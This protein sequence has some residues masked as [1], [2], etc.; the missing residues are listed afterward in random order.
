MR[1]ADGAQR[2]GILAFFAPVCREDQ[3]QWRRKTPKQPVCGSPHGKRR[4]MELEDDGTGAGSS[5]Q[6]KRPRGS[7]VQK[8]DANGSL[9]TGLL[10][11]RKAKADAEETGAPD[12]L[13]SLRR[14]VMRRF[15]ESM[16]QGMVVSGGK[17]R[18]ADVVV[19]RPPATVTVSDDGPCALCD[20]PKRFCVCDS[21]GHSP[22]VW[23]DSRVP[24]GPS[25]ATHDGKTPSDGDHES[26][27]EVETHL[28]RQML[29]VLLRLEKQGV[30]L[31]SEG[32]K[33]GVGSACSTSYCRTTREFS[34]EN[35]LRI[36]AMAV[37]DMVWGDE[38]VF[39]TTSRPS[40]VD[41]FQWKNLLEA[42]L[43][44]HCSGAPQTQGRRR[45]CTT[46]ITNGE[47]IMGFALAG[48]SPSFG[49]SGREVNAKFKAKLA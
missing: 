11:H 5:S 43:A 34:L 8:G 13:L 26:E 39:R 2:S 49:K 33:R 38:K 45:T 30:W 44:Q 42:A 25:A 19:S 9:Q 29:R 21:M 14:R 17:A 35:V 24:A 41:S 4:G 22:A 10:S 15:A 18:S 36:K 20:A 6:H 12:Y 27:S 47:L 37:S 48:L 32:N 46:P 31:T 7:E 3:D 1:L 16:N 40:Q 28:R 23:S